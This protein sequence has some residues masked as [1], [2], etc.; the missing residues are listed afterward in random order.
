M[1]VVMNWVRFANGMPRFQEQSTR[2]QGTAVYDLDII[3]IKFVV[4]FHTVLRQKRVLVTCEDGSFM[5][6]C[7]GS[8]CSG[9]L[10]DVKFSQF[11]QLILYTT[12]VD[13]SWSNLSFGFFK[14]EPTVLTG[15]WA[16]FTSNCPKVLAIF[17]E[18]PWKY[19]KVTKPLWLW[20]WLFW[21]WF[22]ALGGSVLQRY[23]NAIHFKLLLNKP[24]RRSI[25]A[26]KRWEKETKC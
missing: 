15:L 17:S 7:S 20:S 23:W 18:I 25:T 16:T 8:Q 14:M 26:A 19:G 12:R 2:S 1:R 21:G 5:F 11:L 13:R 9:C 4:V 10:T 24:N 22:N 6:F 3:K